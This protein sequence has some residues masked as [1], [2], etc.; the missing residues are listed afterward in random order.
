MSQ[1][2]KIDNE[3]VSSLLFDKD[4]Q[5]KEGYKKFE[6]INYNNEDLNKFKDSI[7]S[8]LNQRD[9]IYND[10]FI[11]FKI[12]SDKIVNDYETL[13]HLTNDNF[14]KIFDTQTKV[15]Y[16]LNQLKEFEPFVSKTNDQLVSHDIRI[17]NMRE[18][19]SLA[20][21]KYDKIYLDNLELP[22]YIGR[23][24]KYK[25]CQNFFLDVIKDLAKLNKYKEKN[26]IDLKLYK[27]KLES[28]I[29]SMNSILDNNNQSQM[30][31]IKEA[32]EHILKECEDMFY[33]VRENMKEI[34][35]ENSKYTIDLISQSMDLSKKWEKIEKIKD[36]IFEKFNYST[37]KYQ[38]LT[39]D[40]IKAFGE[41]KTEYGIIRKKFLELAEFIKDIR[42][43]KNIGENVKRKEIKTI[44]KKIMKKRKTFDG[45][46]VQI[47]NDIAAIDNIDYKKYYDVEKDVDEHIKSK[48]MNKKAKN[49]RKENNLNQNNKNELRQST[50]SSNNKNDLRQSINNSYNSKVTNNNFKLN[51]SINNNLNTRS[52]FEEKKLNKNDSAKNLKKNIK[53][54]NLNSKKNSTII[55]ENNHENENYSIK[56]K[57]D[58]SNQ[59]DENEETNINTYINNTNDDKSLSIISKSDNLIKNAKFKIFRTNIEIKPSIIEDISSISEVNNTNSIR[60]TK[61]M[62]IGPSSEKSLSFISEGNNTNINKFAINE[63][64]SDLNND[65]IIKELASELE[66]TTA[67][68][69]LKGSH[70]KEIEKKFQDACESIEPLKLPLQNS[71]N[72]SNKDINSNN[73]INSNRNINSNIN[74]NSNNKI[75]SN[76]NINSN[77]QINSNNNINSND[78]INSNVHINSNSNINLNNNINTNSNINSNSNVD[79]NSNINYDKKFDMIDTKVDNLEN[80][81]KEKIFDLIG[82]I[83]SIKEIFNLT[84]N[85]INKT[86]NYIPNIKYKTFNSTFSQNVHELNNQRKDKSIDKE[87]MSTN[88]DN[89]NKTNICNSVNNNISSTNSTKRVNEISHKDKKRG[90][91]FREKYDKSNNFDFK[92]QKLKSSLTELNNGIVKSFMKSNINEIVDNFNTK[93]QQNINNNLSYKLLKDA[94]KKNEKKCT[95]CFSPSSG[96]KYVD[97]SKL[98]SRELKKSRLNPLH[99]NEFDYLI[100]L[101]K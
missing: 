51:Y 80:Y 39:D 35:V 59:K 30:K 19:F 83:N 57:E 6:S 60:K 101:S 14:S 69:E 68:R 27:E 63:L 48:S 5:I 72:N 13:K 21:Q 97:L 22:G 1:E 24:A 94:E 87:N 42:F 40:T 73:K 78:N 64:K 52:E 7:L 53:N 36:E 95:T 44:V 18:D 38:M 58:K 32:K 79:S 67:K 29:N 86:Q 41:F 77:I 23:C 26:M 15:T 49:A 11:D 84:I 20:I 47:L 17:K 66:Q 12:A 45:K 75:S 2:E 55:N 92:K 74:I 3:C 16:R 100:Q 56:E 85:E 9:R 54:S 70:K 25:N 89:N 90:F 93:M 31:Y 28:I 99:L 88:I 82:Q 4:R 46:D 37:N 8:L 96:I 81:T 62:N 34:R 71:N 61:S 43:R 76:D 33:S 65:K 91:S 98:F 50:N 10:K